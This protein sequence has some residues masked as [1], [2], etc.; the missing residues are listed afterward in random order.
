LG[1]FFQILL[2]VSLSAVTM[3]L[4]GWVA[5]RA[6]G[7]DSRDHFSLAMVLVVRNVASATAIAVT[8]LGR[9]EFAVFATAYFLDP[10]PIL[11][12]TLFLFRRIGSS[13]LR[14]GASRNK[15][16]R[17]FLMELG[18]RFGCM[19]ARPGSSEGPKRHRPFHGRPLP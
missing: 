14:V 12:V 13:A 10:L 3:M 11:V 9:L 5:G 4:L 1:N 15:R 2:A 16:N 6:Y 19:L 18:C 17:E 8:V 7:L